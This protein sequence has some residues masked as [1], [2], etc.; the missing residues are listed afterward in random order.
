MTTKGICLATFRHSS[1]PCRSGWTY[2]S[3]PRMSR[4]VHRLSTFGVLLTLLSAL[5]LAA[6]GGAHRIALPSA[7]AEALAL[8]YGQTAELCGTVGGKS[9][10]SEECPVCHLV[11]AAVLPKPAAAAKP[12]VLRFAILTAPAAPQRAADSPLDPAHGTRAPPVA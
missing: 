12:V 11:S 1:G 10:L 3:L 5:S 6:A 7:A 8:T 4:V 9:G 2:A